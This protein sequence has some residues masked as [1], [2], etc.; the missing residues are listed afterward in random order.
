MMHVFLR[1]N[2][3]RLAIR[4]VETPWSDKR[5][6]RVLGPS[7]LNF[8]ENINYPVF[9]QDDD[10]ALSP[11][12]AKSEET[13]QPPASDSDWDSH[14]ASGPLQHVVL[15][16]PKGQAKRPL[17]PLLRMEPLRRFNRNNPS[18]GLFPTPVSAAAH[19]SSSTTF[20][21][22]NDD[23]DLPLLPAPVFLRNHDRSESAGSSVTVQI[24]LRLS[25]RNFAVEPIK[26]SPPSIDG[27][28]M[29]PR[30]TCFTNL[31]DW[32]EPTLTPSSASNE[33]SKDFESLSAQIH[34][35]RVVTPIQ[36]FFQPQAITHDLAEH[37]PQNSVP[38]Q[39][40][41]PTELFTL[42]QQAF[43]CLHSSSCFT[44]ASCSTICTKFCARSEQSL[45]SSSSSSTSRFFTKT[46]PEPT[47][48]VL[49]TAN[50]QAS[51]TFPQSAGQQ[52]QNNC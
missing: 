47:A 50:P 9:W 37:K 40:L 49:F 11:S 5:A 27:L 17:T 51:A 30:T 41:V 21:N 38:Q 14:S 1:S 20:A 10:Y 13:S 28:P 12:F 4:A 42:P 8:R 7:N 43:L 48:N 6:I 39:P 29:A 2:A 32:S 52:T 34:K 16:S 46:T 33:T 3:D 35:A 25:Y 36:I 23:I 15:P 44:T 26:I 19:M 45:I 31:E 24:G 18:Y 22:I